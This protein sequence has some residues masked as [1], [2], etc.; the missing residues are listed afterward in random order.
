MRVPHGNSPLARRLRSVA[1][2]VN[3]HSLSLC[4][5]G[6]LAVYACEHWGLSFAL[7][8][9]VI[10]FGVTF[11]ASRVVALSPEAR[12]GVRVRKLR[13]RVFAIRRASRH[14]SRAGA[15]ELAQRKQAAGEECAAV[16]AWAFPPTHCCGRPAILNLEE[17]CPNRRCRQLARMLWKSHLQAQPAAAL[18]H[19]SRALALTFC[20]RHAPDTCPGDVHHHP[21]VHAQGEG[22]H[23]HRGAQGGSPAA[24]RARTQ[25][26]TAA[27]A[28]A[29]LE[30]CEGTRGAGPCEGAGLLAWS[31]ERQPPRQAV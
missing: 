6:C 20:M 8:I 10:V 16:C 17:R 3:L 1:W 23:H 22:P 19:I 13:T 21:G 12:D 14:C 29:A 9:S 2:V 24:R 27:C 11:P 4:A 15:S 25:S 7:D 28:R 26:G 5:V 30:T 18:G 31:A